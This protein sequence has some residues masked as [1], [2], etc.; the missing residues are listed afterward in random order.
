MLQS[1]AQA[2]TFIAPGTTGRVQT[3]GELWSATATEPINAGEMVRIVGLDG[4]LLKVRPD[5]PAP[6][7]PVGDGVGRQAREG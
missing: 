4:L 6:A 2:V 1:L 5:R 7:I 3:R